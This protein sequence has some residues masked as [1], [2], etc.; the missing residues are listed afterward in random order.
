M[1]CR[2]GR[3]RRAAVDFV[4]CFGWGGF[5]CPCF[6]FSVFFFFER[7]RPAASMRPP[8]ASFT[9]LLVPGCVQG[10][11]LFNLSVGVCACVTLLRFYCLREL[12]E[13][14]FHKPG[15]Y[16]TGRVWANAWDVFHRT[17]SRGD[18]GRRAAV[19]FVVCFGCG[20]IFFVFFLAFFCFFSNAHS[21][22]QV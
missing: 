11:R 4:V 17:P 8:L 14:D 6:F 2:I 12:Y 15:I 16:G 21:M 22:L 20:G 1:P 5:F 18:R 9:S 3:G 7:T 13:A 10:A 19:D